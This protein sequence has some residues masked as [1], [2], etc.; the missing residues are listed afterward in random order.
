VTLSAFIALTLSPMLASRLVGEHR[1]PGTPVGRWIVRL[2]EALV[3]LYARLLDWALAAPAVVVVAALVFAGAA[4]IGFRLLPSE[5]TPAED[6]GSVQISVSSPQGSTVDYSDSQMRLVERAAQPFLQSGEAISMFSIGRGSGGF[7]F[8]TLA[9]WGE[10]TRTQNEVAAD[11]NRRLQAIPGVQVA[12]RGSNSLG[13]RGGGQGLQFAVLGSDYHSLADAAGKLVRAIEQSPV[14][15]RVQLNYDTTQ[16]QISIDVDRQRASDLGIPIDSIASAVQ[17]LVD[18]KDFGSFY[19][20]DSSIDIVARVPDGM[21][22]DVGALD[23]IDL[24]TRDGKMVPLSS[25]VTFSESAVAPSL[26]RQDQR[27]AI[28]IGATFADGVD[29]RKAMD[30]AQAI[31]AETLPAGTSIA[32]TGDAKELNTASRGVAQTFIFALV[33]VLLV[34]AAQF[35]SFISASILIATVPFGV[36]AAIFAILLTGGSINIYS[37]IGLV[38]LVGLMSKNGILIVEFANQLRDAGQS[39]GQ[40]IRNASLIRLRP[41]V[42]T[43]IATVLGGLPLLLRGG[44][45]S[46][47]RHALGWIIVGGLGFATTATLFLTPVVFSLLARFSKPRIAEEQRLERELREAEAAPGTYRP[48]PEEEGEMREMPELPAAAE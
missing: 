39:V 36:A 27:R 28:P 14:F 43:M 45:G 33:I 15:D 44:A 38:M 47:A 40:A 42:M 23:N 26:P 6:R 34:L 9:P 10:R 30:A 19:V 29:L 31:A 1:P 18:S 4:A 22:Q 48:T 5:L 46:E 32:F 8:L 7:M 13:I 12:A 37:E 16:P 25:L 24:R 11:L 2:G 3:R 20:G 21:I 17:T 35:E 41:V